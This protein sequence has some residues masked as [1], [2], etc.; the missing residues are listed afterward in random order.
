MSTRGNVPTC[1]SRSAI[2][3]V[4]FASQS[5]AAAP[6]LFT[7]WSPARHPSIVQGCSRRVCWRYRCIGTDKSS[8]SL[9]E[10]WLWEV[11]ELRCRQR[12]LREFPRDTKGEMEFSDIPVYTWAVI[13]DRA[14]VIVGLTACTS[15][16]SSTENAGCRKGLKSV[17]NFELSHNSA[18]GMNDMLE[19]K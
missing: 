11:V 10:G 6:S 18:G 7:C 14:G 19:R 4:C 13:F 12:P 9:W 1:G 17:L 8:A 2:Q 5:F 15:G 3:R 16:V